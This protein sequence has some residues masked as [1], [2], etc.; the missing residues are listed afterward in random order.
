MWNTS[1]PTSGSHCY[2]S[3]TSNSFPSLKKAC[4]VEAE[5]D[6]ITEATWNYF[7]WL[8]KSTDTPI[9]ENKMF[10]MTELTDDC[11]VSVSKQTHWQKM[12]LSVVPV[13][14]GE[15]QIMFRGSEGTETISGQNCFHNHFKKLFAFF[16]ATH[17]L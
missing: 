10:H 6:I 7:H 13:K 3:C 16:K 17:F 2:N 11:E 5:Q 8:K 12:A 14:T 4:W 9:V 1:H 15:S